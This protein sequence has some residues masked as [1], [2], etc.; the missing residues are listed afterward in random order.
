[1]HAK[2]RCTLGMLAVLGNLIPAWVPRPVDFTEVQVPL[3][4]KAPV[5][6]KHARCEEKGRSK[7][8]PWRLQ[9]GISLTSFFGYVKY[10]HIPY[11]KRNSAFDILAPI[12]CCAATNDIPGCHL[13]QNPS[14][15][16]QMYA[17][18]IV[19][20]MTFQNTTHMV[21]LMV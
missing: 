7:D 17:L 13:Q 9:F 3:R 21:V 18:Q 14:Y 6:T 12:C 19:L 1:M 5:T 16:F 4:G 11:K 20:R 10:I 8:H 15:Y 2:T